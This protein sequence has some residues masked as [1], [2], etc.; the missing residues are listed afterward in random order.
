MFSNHIVCNGVSIYLTEG[1]LLDILRCYLD[2]N[3]DKQAQTLQLYPWEMT[4]G[5]YK[6]HCMLSGP[7]RFTVKVSVQK[8]GP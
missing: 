7:P 3:L 5:S 2:I 8:Q 1:V 4:V 6:A